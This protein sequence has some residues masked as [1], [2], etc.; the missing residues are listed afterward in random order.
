MVKI[1]LTSTLVLIISILFAVSAEKTTAENR[2][3]AY[4]NDQDQ[5]NEEYWDKLVGTS[6]NHNA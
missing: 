3:L 5:W 2:K 1:T 6:T 4:L